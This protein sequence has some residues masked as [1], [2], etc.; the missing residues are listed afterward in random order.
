MRP[1]IEWNDFRPIY[2]TGTAWNG[3][4]GISRNASIHA[5]FGGKIGGTTFGTIPPFRSFSFSLEKDGTRRGLE[6]VLQSADRTDRRRDGAGG[7]VHLKTRF[8][9]IHASRLSRI[10]APVANLLED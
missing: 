3:W 9:G 6:A 7:L 8:T 4:N 10:P 1:E 2:C 5:A